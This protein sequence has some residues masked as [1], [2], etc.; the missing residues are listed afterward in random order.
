[1]MYWYFDD[2][3]NIYNASDDATTLYGGTADDDVMYG[4][5]GNDTLWGNIGNDTIFGGAGNDYLRGLDGDDI[6]Y[7]EAGDDILAG[8]KGNNILDG[9]AGN[10]TLHGGGS[11]NN[12]LKGGVGDDTYWLYS[13]NDKAMELAL[14]G[15]DTVHTTFSGYT[16]GAEVENLVLDTYLQYYA[17]SGVG[18]AKDNIMYGN[19]NLDNDSQLIE[20]Y[21][22]GGAGNDTLY[23][24][25]GQDFLVGGI[26]NDT[27]NGNDGDDDLRGDAG[28]DT[29]DGGLGADQMYGGAGN[30]TYKVDNVGDS[31]HDDKFD[32][33]YQWIGNDAGG[34]D[35]VVS[36]IEFDIGYVGGNI[37]N[38]T[39]IGTDNIDG[40]GNWFNNTIN[41]NEGDN[42]LYGY[43]GN[44]IL[45]GGDG[46]DT[47]DYDWEGSYGNDTM[48]GGKGDDTYY[49]D[50]DGGDKPIELVSGADGGV[51]TVYSESDYTL[52]SYIEN[53]VLQ[54]ASVGQGNALPNMITADEWRNSF[55]Y[56]LA[57]NDTLYGGNGDDFLDGGTGVDQMYGGDSS[58]TYIVDNAGDYI[59]EA[60]GEGSGWDKVY[61]SVTAVDSPG[62]YTLADNVEELYLTGV[63]NIDGTG[64]GGNNNLYGNAY[65]NSLYGMGGNDQIYGNAGDDKLYGGNGY[66]RLYGGDGKDVL[67][68][69]DGGGYLDGGKG[70]DTMTGG[71]GDDTFIVDATGD[72]VIDSAGNWDEIYSS[73]TY[74][75]PNTI[76]KLILTGTAAINGTGND[77]VN[78][79]VGNAGANTISGLGGN[80][81]IKGG[82]GNDNLYGGD[83][84]DELDMEEGSA[85]GND[86]M[87]GG[88]GSDIY[89]VDST[90][91]KV[92]EVY[93]AVQDVLLLGAA[94]DWVASYNIASYTLPDYVENLALIPGN[95]A[96]TLNGTGNSLANT[97]VGN[98]GNNVLNGG[99][100]GD[101]MAGGGGDDT[102]WVDSLLDIVD[103]RYLNYGD[104]GPELIDGANAGGSDTVIT[105]LDYD[106]SIYEIN[107][108]AVLENL[109]FLSAAGAAT[110]T[111]NSLDNVMTGNGMSSLLS[112][113]AGNDTYIISGNI[114]S[115]YDKVEEDVD[116]GTDT[117]KSF[118]ENYTLT[119]NVE[120]LILSGT[121]LTGTGNGDGNM[122]LGNDKNNTLFGLAGNDLLNGGKG[123]DTMYGGNGDDTYWV[124][125]ATDKVIDTDGLDQVW[126]SVTYTLGANVEDL[127]LTGVGAIN[128]TGNDLNNTISGNSRNNILSGGAG[129]DV[130]TGGLGSDTLNGGDDADDLNGGGGNDTLRGDAGNDTLDG[131]LG[132]DVLTGGTGKDDFAFTTALSTTANKDT[133]TDFTIDALHPENEDTIT[134]DHTVFGSLMYTGMLH[135][136][137]FMIGGAAGGSDDYIIYNQTTGALFYDADGNG[138][139]SP[140]IQFAILNNKAALNNTVFTVV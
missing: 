108:T 49:L 51:D 89:C 121:V 117:V 93:E 18:N 86:T 125:V 85:A 126:S 74:S 38:L 118:V 28:N 120:N 44:D 79:I 109:T 130:L 23:G 128:G 20:N 63:L 55:L 61:S 25:L 129:K 50:W 71:S 35:T 77:E 7:G 139:A 52:G 48:Y 8:N 2:E 29:L 127:H 106:L 124:D 110:G 42:F 82:A 67:E 100:G 133:I 132:N 24:Q 56:G 80:D 4:Y 59:E 5:G 47:F 3:D 96:L 94:G 32:G 90:G 14:G 53:L 105:S 119:A 30:D 134:L 54:N 116:E 138:G 103:E 83:G 36:S 11:G 81:R 114:S 78:S 98:W 13:I 113:G 75:M 115:D 37:E 12:L 111:G 19:A 31:I 41:G 73:V 62:N 58:D 136:D 102:Y 135:I 131:G 92:I 123:S 40:Y 27:L 69:G 84:N 1:M 6:I 66:D 16:L 107:G 26:G 70:V 10:D 65:K 91:D 140:A 101:Y 97:I 68:G 88:K 39:L 17:A 99:T 57:E 95:G 46:N 112:G 21:L 15:T 43:D 60:G 137:N 64:N 33:N 122:L 72:Q 45:Y 104:D 9:G 76:E 22:D 34:I 87:Y